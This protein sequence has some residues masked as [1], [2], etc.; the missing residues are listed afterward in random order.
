VLLADDVD[1]KSTAALLAAL[2]MHRVWDRAAAVM[3]SAIPPAKKK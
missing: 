3:A 1:K 2:G